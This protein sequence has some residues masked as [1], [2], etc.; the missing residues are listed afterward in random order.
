MRS[1]RIDKNTVE[2]KVYYNGSNPAC[3]VS[4]TAQKF[5]SNREFLNPIKAFKPTENTEITYGFDNAS[6]GSTG[7]YMVSND[8]LTSVGDTVTWLVRIANTSSGIL[9]NVWLAQKSGISG[10]SIASVRRVNCGTNMPIGANIPL[11]V[12]GYYKMGNVDNSGICLSIKATFT[13]CIKDSLTL[14]SGFSCMGYPTSIQNLNLLCGIAEQ[15]VY[16]HPA[17][18]QLQQ[19]IT[20]QPSVDVDLC[21]VMH[22]KIAVNSSQKGAVNSIITQLEILPGQGLSIQTGTSKV[23]YPHNS[24]RNLRHQ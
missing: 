1:R 10:V 13:N 24:S 15:K 22:Y 17:P 6:A 14:I 3:A 19:I 21:E 12:K 9:N 2:I 5:I 8:D 18:T 7:F 23:E 4:A 11:D 20:A 16:V